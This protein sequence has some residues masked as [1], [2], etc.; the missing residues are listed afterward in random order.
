LM[1]MFAAVFVMLLN[2]GAAIHLSI[3]ESI[4]IE[5]KQIIQLI[6]KMYSV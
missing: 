6:L 1:L 4:D 2:I 3:N 5:H